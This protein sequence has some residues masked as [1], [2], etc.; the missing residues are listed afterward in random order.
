[1]AAETLSLR[2]ADSR[3]RISERVEYNSKGLAIRIY[4]P[5]FADRHGYINDQSLRELG[6]SDRQFYDSLGRPTRT[7]T[8][9][10]F[11]RRM[12]YW[13]WY[14]VSEDENDTQGSA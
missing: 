6:Y 11:M 3:W 13:A 1:M 9:A 4:R 8:A 14:T 2:H 5:Y 12:T 7:L 10:G